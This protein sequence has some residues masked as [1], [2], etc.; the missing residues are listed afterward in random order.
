M[1]PN[2][3][4]QLKVVEVLAPSVDAFAGTKTLG[5]VRTDDYDQVM[6]AITIGA[7]SA[8]GRTKIYAYG[9][10][11]VAGTN[12]QPCGYWARIGGNADADTEGDWTRYE[13]GAEL[14]PTANQSDTQWLIAIDP[15][16]ASAVNRAAGYACIGVA[17]VCVE[18]VDDTIAAS[19]VAICRPVRNKETQEAALLV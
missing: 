13:A 15:V 4:M 7:V 5:P 10:P 18:A 12:K 2:E 17:L 6:F 16:E 9:Y 19:A 1:R 3:L 14:T 8:T 11:I